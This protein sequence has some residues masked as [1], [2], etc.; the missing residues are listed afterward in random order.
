MLGSLDALLIEKLCKGGI[1]F[2]LNQLT[3]INGIDKEILA[4]ILEGKLFFVVSTN[5]F[6]HTDHIFIHAVLTKE[7]C[8]G[9]LGIS[10]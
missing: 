10:D 8:Q 4:D 2:L 1:G 5:N 6:K 7:G 3:Q 9:F